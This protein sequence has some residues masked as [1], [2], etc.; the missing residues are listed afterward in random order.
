MPVL[1]IPEDFTEQDWFNLSHKGWAT[2]EVRHLEHIYEIE[3]YDPVRLGQD[4]ESMGNCL[5]FSGLIVLK[6][7][8]LPEILKALDLAEKEGLFKSLKPIRTAGG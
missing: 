8:A 1:L 2:F 5:I 6:E 7:V 3:F 4:L